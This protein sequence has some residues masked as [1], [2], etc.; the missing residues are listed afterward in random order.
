M[1]YACESGTYK[2]TLDEFDALNVRA[3]LA[4]RTKSEQLIH[5]GVSSLETKQKAKEE[6][7]Y[8]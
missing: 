3:R 8:R 6:T 4:G 1:M 5:E 7:D 2:M